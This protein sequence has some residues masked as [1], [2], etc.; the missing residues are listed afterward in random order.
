MTKPDR[1]TDEDAFDVKR[2][3]RH[4]IGWSVLLSFALIGGVLVFFAVRQFLTSGGTPNL[5]IALI[6]TPL[7]V[8]T[9]YYLYRTMPDFTMGEPNT[10]R[11]NQSRSIMVAVVLVGLAIGFPII[12]ADSEQGGA[13]LWSNGPIP[14]TA[15][16]AALLI[17]AAALPIL[18]FAG[19]HYGDEHTVGVHDFSMMVAGSLFYYLAPIWWIGWRGGFFPQPDVMVLFVIALIAATVANYWKRFA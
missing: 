7:M 5:L 16:L 1:Q 11:G 14:A 17:W 2:Y 6:G 9:G 3:F 12:T 8:L 15:A 10:K 19:R 13:L 4:L 18:H